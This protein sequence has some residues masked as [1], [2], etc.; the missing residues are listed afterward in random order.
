VTAGPGGQNL[1]YVTG[2]NTSNY[3][4]IRNNF[5]SFLISNFRLVLNVVFF[6][7]DDFRASEYYVPTFRNTVPSS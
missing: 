2:I 1:V 7:L 6:L 4:Y 5:H 3:N